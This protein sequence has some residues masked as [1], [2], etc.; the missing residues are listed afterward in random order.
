MQA[1]PH[2]RGGQ[3]RLAVDRGFARLEHRF[4]R[5]ML[6]DYAAGLQDTCK[7]LLFPEHHKIRAEWAYGFVSLKNLVWRDGT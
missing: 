3:N 1:L 2:H 7:L 4:E 6:S 5:S